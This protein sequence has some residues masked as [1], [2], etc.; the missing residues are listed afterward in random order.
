MQETITELAM[1]YMHLQETTRTIASM[2]KRLCRCQQ[3]SESESHIMGGLCKVYRDLNND[4]GDLSED[5][6]LVDFLRQSQIEE[7]S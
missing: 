6:N 3:S 5:N 1:A 7:T 4:F 2:P